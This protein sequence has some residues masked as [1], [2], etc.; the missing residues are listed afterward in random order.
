M[1]TMWRRLSALGLLAL[2]AGVGACDSTPLY[3]ADNP[4]SPR[5]LQASYFNGA[6]TLTW[7]LAPGWNGESFRVFGKRVSDA[8][9]FLIAE[10]TNCI[11]GACSYDD[12]NVVEGTSYE[13][14]VA[15]VD[16][17]TGV[18]TATQNSVLVDIPLADAPDV[19]ANPFAV[20]LDNA[21]YLIWDGNARDASDFSFYRVYNDD[22]T[23]VFLLG[24]TDSEGFLDL[25]AG[26]GNTYTYLVT[27][28]DNAGH[29]S[30]YSVAADGTP[31]P[32]FTGEWIYADGDQP[33]QSAFRFA[34]AEDIDPIL[35]GSDAAQHFRLEVDANGWWLVP[36]AG[37]EIH[38]SGFETTTLKC[39]V[40]AD[41]GCTSLDAAPTSGY[42]TQDVAV[43]DQ[44]TYPMR[45]IGDD[46]Q[47]HYGVIRVQLLG[48]DQN[49]ASIMI[50][51]WAYQLQAGNANLEPKATVAP[52]LR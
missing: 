40:G 30:D 2:A 41:A 39:G 21:I 26:N 22:G 19:P 37:T 42:T 4:D 51:D 36:G 32:D 29:E 9:Y 35:A 12:I 47:M 14:Y 45:V 7:E 6:V 31:R 17:D 34:D 28:V 3:Y 43:F 48:S 27:S 1:T 38:E 52:R 8:D 10:V 15:S 50:F 25:L 49:G 46:G 20:T 11:Q 33:A 23:D 24:E 5:N 16:P 18:E 44:T 13:Y